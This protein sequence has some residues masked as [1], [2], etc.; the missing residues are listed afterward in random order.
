MNT[1]QT[2]YA[3]ALDAV[4]GTLSTGHARQVR[5]RA[6][7]FANYCIATGLDPLT[8]A[9]PDWDD[10]VRSQGWDANRGSKEKSAV[11]LVLAAAGRVAGDHGLR[12]GNERWRLTST[13][14]P[15]GHIEAFV[16]TFYPQRISVC[17]SALTRFWAW[18]AEFGAEPFAI[19][20]RDADDFAWWLRDTKGMPRSGEIAMIGRDWAWYLTTG[21][22][23]PRQNRGGTKPKDAGLAR[24]SQTVATIPPVPG[25]VA[26]LS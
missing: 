15:E 4:L 10:Y 16:T 6:N 13:N 9:G 5:P 12:P 20:S 3:I 7:R 19:T 1:S 23:R 24:R 22:R 11:R 14:D 26:A 21:Q 8:I 2:T 18:A 25:R 17:R